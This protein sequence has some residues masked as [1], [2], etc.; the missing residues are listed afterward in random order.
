MIEQIK[1]GNCDNLFHADVESHFAEGYRMRKIRDIAKRYVNDVMVHSSISRNT[2][3]GAE[4]I[5]RPDSWLDKFTPGEIKT[6]LTFTQQLADLSY[7]NSQGKINLDEISKIINELESGMWDNYLLWD[8]VA[9]Q[10]LLS[11]KKSSEANI[12]ILN[13]LQQPPHQ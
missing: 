3:S 7:Y 6:I 10:N 11:Q 1:K 13:Y 2:E 8:N 5:I 4:D 9:Y 12:R